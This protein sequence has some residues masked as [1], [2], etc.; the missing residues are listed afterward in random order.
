MKERILKLFDSILEE[1]PTKDAD[2][3]R[4]QGFEVDDDEILP[5]ENK[6]LVTDN[7]NE[8]LSEEIR[9]IFNEILDFVKCGDVEKAFN[10]YKLIV[11][12]S[13]K[14]LYKIGQDLDN[15]DSYGE[16]DVDFDLIDSIKKIS[17]ESRIGII[18]TLRYSKNDELPQIIFTWLI[19]EIIRAEYARNY[20]YITL[21]DLFIDL[22]STSSVL[23]E[24]AEIFVSTPVQSER[25]PHAF[26]KLCYS[27]ILGN[28][29]EAKRIIAVNQ[30]E[31][32][33][34]K[35]FI[36]QMYAKNLI[37][38]AIEITEKSLQQARLEE[39]QILKLTFEERARQYPNGKHWQISEFIFWCKR[40][41][42]DKLLELEYY[43][44]AI[45]FVYQGFVGSAKEG[46]YGRGMMEYYNILKE[47]L[48]DKRKKYL[49]ERLF[50]SLDKLSVYTVRD[51]CI[52]EDFWPYLL[53]SFKINN[54]LSDVLKIYSQCK[55][56]LIV[57]PE[58]LAEMFY[59]VISEYVRT[60]SGS[61]RKK[62]IKD[63]LRELSL[64]KNSKPLLFRLLLNLKKN[65]NKRSVLLNLIYEFV[66]EN[67]FHEEYENYEIENFD[68]SEKNL[69]F[70]GINPGKNPW[71][72]PDWLVSF[73]GILQNKPYLH[74][75]M[76][77]IDKSGEFSDLPDDIKSMLLE[78]FGNAILTYQKSKK[79]SNIVADK[80][81][82]ALKKYREL[83]SYEAQFFE[84]IFAIQIKH[85]KKIVLK[86]RLEEYIAEV[87]LDESLHSWAEKED[88]L[89]EKYK[90]HPSRISKPKKLYWHENEWAENK[91]LE[92]RSLQ[93][94]FENK[95]NLPED[96]LVLNENMREQLF[97]IYRESIFKYAAQSKKD[98]E[99]K[100]RKIKTAIEDI[101]FFYSKKESLDMLV[102]E[103]KR[104]YPMRLKLNN[105]LDNI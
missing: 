64:I 21:R 73:K 71:S 2:Y 62:I 93:S 1:N 37:Y 43:D 41:I 47:R 13:A 38:D 50:H 30:S 24:L 53:D 79:G 54:R 69:I 58:D 66:L 20:H 27:I 84:L 49:A 17:D 92:L 31:Y 6:Y 90:P 74:E 85:P 4:A 61:A 9:K 98:E 55:E 100:T 91:L 42:I 52:E 68:K 19:N 103:L 60:G 28:Y 25:I 39:I 29:E 80:T 3:Y 23:N 48:P 63:G 11:R 75:L 99:T 96:P 57:F 14:L 86:I 87:G 46:G 72:N 51:L 101:K 26:L 89:L 8:R 105:M 88:K 65:Y 34:N 36:E 5:D 94:I 10:A 7:A 22:C 104:N 82:A 78:S 67:N 56:Q 32:K 95:K 15:C 33:L 102:F 70:N 76:R 45:D 97:N 18:N 40:F 12:E 81:I 16:I 35:Y 83:V 59:S 77:I 44:R